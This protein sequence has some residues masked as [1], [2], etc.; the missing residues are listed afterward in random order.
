MQY[1]VSAAWGVK[2]IKSNHTAI[3]LG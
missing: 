2:G 1:E 3:L